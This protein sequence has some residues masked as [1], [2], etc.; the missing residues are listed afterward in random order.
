[1]VDDNSDNPLNLAW[2]MI[3][4]FSVGYGILPHERD[5]FH[6]TFATPSDSFV[7]RCYLHMDMKRANCTGNFR[8]LQLDIIAC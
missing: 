6:C 2:H 8:G 5:E 4:R 3:L 7:L 1:V